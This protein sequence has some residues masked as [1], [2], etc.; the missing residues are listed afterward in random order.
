MVNQHRD[1]YASYVGHHALISYFAVA[2]NE[3]IARVKFEFV[4]VSLVSQSRKCY[5]LVDC[6]YQET[7]KQFNQSNCQRSTLFIKWRRMLMNLISIILQNQGVGLNLIDHSN[8]RPS[9]VRSRF[10]SLQIIPIGF[11]GEEANTPLAHRSRIT[12]KPKV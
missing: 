6:L 2:Q 11:L 10:F 3:C 9:L 1:S 7:N 12:F 5:N 8:D 4:E